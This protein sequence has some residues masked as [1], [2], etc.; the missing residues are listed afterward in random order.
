M[1]DTLKERITRH[2]ELSGLLPLAEYMHW[3]MADRDF[4]YYNSANVLGRQGDFITAPEVSQMF[5]EMLAIW[6]IQ[7]W[8]NLGSPNTVNLVELGPG[9]GTM[10]SDILRTAKVADAFSQAI[11]VTLVETSPKLKQIQEKTLEEYENIT[12]CKSLSDIWDLPTILFANEFLDVIPFRQYVK[13]NGKWPENCVGL[14]DTRELSWVLGA[15]FIDEQSLPAGHKNEPEGSVFEVS[16]AREAFVEKAS[17]LI[18]KNTGAALFL[19]Y[20]HAQS[21]FGDTFQAIK[22]HEYTNPLSA[23]GL[24]DLTSHVDFEALSKTA[25]EKGLYVHPLLT[26]GEFL[27]GLGLAE[28]AG[29]LGQDKSEEVQSRLRS[30]AE[31]LVMP[32]Q[33][34]NLF[35]AFA[36]STFPELVP[37]SKEG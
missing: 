23:P 1:A 28:R 25:T 26:Q 21:G 35:K 4:G 15:S 37:F 22:G 13:H 16:T 2:I 11:S 33:M 3:C 29:A 6:A 9:R 36:I 14:S 24:C 32:E 8:K 7:A 10:M 19:D 12:W 20:G 34:G 5:G 30:E 31:R 18:R 27:L 17:D